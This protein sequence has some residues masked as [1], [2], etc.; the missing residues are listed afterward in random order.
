MPASLEELLDKVGLQ[1]VFIPSSLEG[2]ME[3]IS[4]WVFGT[5]GDARNLYE[6]IAFVQEAATSNVDDYLLLGQAGH[7]MQSYAMH[8]YLVEGQLALFL[9]MAWGGA[10]DDGEADRAAIAEQFALIPQ[11]YNVVLESEL[12][13]DARLVVALSDMH[14]SRWAVLPEMLTKGEVLAFGDWQ[15]EDA[16]DLRSVLDWLNEEEFG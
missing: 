16:V 9:Q 5:R 1:K 7:G 6:F 2:E 4:D 11:L 14:G 8:Y 12:P 3:R 10:Y 13:E 15:T